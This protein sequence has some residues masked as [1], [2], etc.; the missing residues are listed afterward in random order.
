M[1]SNFNLMKE[2][3]NSLMVHRY[4]ITSVYTRNNHD[5]SVVNYFFKVLVTKIIMGNNCKLS[6]LLL[7][8][9]IV[10]HAGKP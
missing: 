2:V 6:S 8:K 3:P 5:I 7:Y 10:Y 1:F 4:A 9:S